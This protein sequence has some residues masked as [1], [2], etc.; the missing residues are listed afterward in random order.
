[1]LK[2]ERRQTDD[3]GLSLKLAG[4]IRGPWVEELRRVTEAV[5]AAAVPLRLDLLDV[6]FVDRDGVVLLARLAR[7]DVTLVNC[8]AFV[9]E[10]LRARS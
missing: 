2:I 1:M 7:R 5:L 4:E 3:G 6:A 9:T 8:S 10:L